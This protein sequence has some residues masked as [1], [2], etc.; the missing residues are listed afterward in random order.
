V[1][2]VDAFQSDWGNASTGEVPSRPRPGALYVVISGRAKYGGLTVR[3]P[4]KRW[5][6]H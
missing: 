6:T 3:Y 5:F 4:R 2:N 1:V